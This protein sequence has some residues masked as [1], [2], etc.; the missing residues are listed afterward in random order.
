M[1]KLFMLFLLCFILTGFTAY[2][3][4]ANEQQVPTLIS[5]SFKNAKIEGE[6][7]PE[8]NEYDLTLDN[9]EIS[10][11]LEDFDID[12]TGRLFVNYILD[13]ARHQKGICVTLEFESGSTIYNFNY[14]N[15]YAYKITSN[16]SLLEIT[17]NAV[18][19]YPEISDKYRNYRLY[20]PSDTTTLKLTAVPKDISASV[21]IPEE[22][23]IALDQEPVIPVTVTASNGETRLYK[24]SVKRVDKTTEEI[25]ALMRSGELKTLAEDE[26]FYR[27]PVF[28]IILASVILGILFVA[29][30]VSTA[31]RI[32]VKAD[33]EDEEEFFC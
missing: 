26:L 6:F 20:I 18:E 29:L 4:E 10:P 13:D 28:Y 31:K 24:L 14:T 15:A 30:I 17:G 2:A 22:I 8:I 3:Q 19:V 11:T 9:P 7:S 27:K 21:N 32:S 12:G 25:E 16:N 33:D 1:K 5:I 23:E